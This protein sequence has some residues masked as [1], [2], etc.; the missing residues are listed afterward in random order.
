MF[1]TVSALYIFSKIPYDEVA[2]KN[3]IF[4][5]CV[6]V[7]GFLEVH[8]QNTFLIKSNVL[9]KRF[10]LLVLLGMAIASVLPNIFVILCIWI[11]GS[12]DVDLQALVVFS[13]GFVLYVIWIFAH[14]YVMSQKNININKSV[15]S[16]GSE[17]PSR[18]DLQTQSLESEKIIK[19]SSKDDPVLT[20]NS[21]EINSN[22]KFNAKNNT[23]DNKCKL[24]DDDHEGTFNKKM[25]NEKNEE[26]HQEDSESESENVNFEYIRRSLKEK[27]W[28]LAGNF[29]L[30]FVS[31]SIFPVLVFEVGFYYNGDS[32][33]SPLAFCFSFGDVLGRTMGSY[34][35]F[36]RKNSII[37]YYLI[38]LLYFGL[39]L[40]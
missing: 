39:Y 2:F 15:D 19:S 34:L 28:L 6:F 29:L 12:N 4:L 37:F 40:A 17:C 38:R 32:V 25:M 11:S 36:K 22:K 26:L 27:G 7:V 10:V 16:A 18:I 31:L 9:G 20:L 8:L 30:F 13:S 3:Y 35:H 1:V 21:L 23:N 14:I 5:G 33:K 24:L